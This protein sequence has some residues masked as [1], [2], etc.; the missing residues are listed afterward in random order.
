MR[1]HTFQLAKWRNVVALG[2]PYLDTTVKTG[3]SIFAPNWD[4]VMRVKSGAISE[5]EYTDRYKQLMRESFLANKLEWLE[6]IKAPE[7]AVACYCPS[8]RF[9]HRLILV[10]LLEALCRAHSV[11]FEYAGELQ[12]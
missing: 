7:L 3:N 2:I 5:V 4:I 6:T 11:P 8:G 1:L 10:E 9:C 12:L